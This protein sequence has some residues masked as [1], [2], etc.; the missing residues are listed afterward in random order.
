MD[1]VTP[2]AG[3]LLLKLG[4]SNSLDIQTWPNELRLEQTTLPQ[5]L[6]S[7]WLDPVILPGF[8]VVV[9]LKCARAEFSLALLSI[10]LTFKA[11]LCSSRSP[12]KR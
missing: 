9:A 8:Y 6:F 4:L 2:M 10:L 1:L 12:H 11:G 3:L 7:G 5:H